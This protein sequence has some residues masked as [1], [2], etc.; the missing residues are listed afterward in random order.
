MFMQYT[1]DLLLCLCSVIFANYVSPDL[2]NEISTCRI[3]GDFTASSVPNLLRHNRNMHA[4]AYRANVGA[5]DAFF[6]QPSAS[7]PRCELCSIYIGTGYEMS[8]LQNVFHLQAQQFR[9]KALADARL[10]ADASREK[11]GDD[12]DD[13]EDDDHDWGNED[14]GGGEGFGGLGGLGDGD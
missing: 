10:L 3:C 12:D 13:Y 7:L 6:E 4:D 2:M 8:H 11:D 9:D 14:H 1:F 5:G